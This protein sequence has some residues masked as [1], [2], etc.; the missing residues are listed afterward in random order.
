[1][2]INILARRKIAQDI[3]DKRNKDRVSAALY[4]K[5]QNM[6]SDLFSSPFATHIAVSL[7]RQRP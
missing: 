2:M 3:N 7:C 5:R 1:M 6:C 4:K